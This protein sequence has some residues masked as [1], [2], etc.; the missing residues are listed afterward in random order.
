MAQRQVIIHR[1]RPKSTR[2]QNSIIWDERISTAARFSLIAMLS[3]PDSWDYSVRGMATMLKVSK[4]TMGKYLKELEQAGYLRRNQSCTTGGRFGNTQYI[5]TDTPGDFGEEEPCP[6]N[7]DTER[8][9]T[10]P[11][12]NLPDPVLPDP[13]KSPQKKRTEQ[14]RRT[15]QGSPQ[16]PP[17][18]GRKSKYAL[19]DDAKPL[20]R[21]YV[22]QDNE[23][24]R[25]LAD[26][27][28]LREQLRAVNSAV[29]IKALLSKLDKLSGGDRMMKLLLIEEAIANSWKSV[30]PLKGGVQPAAHPARRAADRDDGG[31]LDCGF[32]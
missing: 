12:P 22:G 24:A 6:K 21:A 3:L 15:E 30:F 7:Q 4:D 9:T 2:I 1:A 25:A 31:G 20:L 26:F 10:P 29:A 32:R 17:V 11:C 27:I 28:Q 16:S 23:L 5:L 8:E 18:G 13:E 19:Q 14:W